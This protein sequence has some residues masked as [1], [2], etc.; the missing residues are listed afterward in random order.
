MVDVP[1]R[2]LQ[3]HSRE[4][5]A[6]VDAGERL[7]ITRAG[8]PVAELRPVPR[9]PTTAATLLERWSKSP[10]VDPDAL[11]ADIDQLADNSL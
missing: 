8:H 5:I 2:D 11:R 7:T 3:L 1:I 9:R 4:V 6:R 10:R